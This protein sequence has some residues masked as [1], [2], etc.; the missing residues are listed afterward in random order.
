MLRPGEYKE[1][2]QRAYQVLGAAAWCQNHTD[3]EGWYNEGYIDACAR[4]SLDRLNGDLEREYRS[5]ESQSW[6]E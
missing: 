6:L 4:W 2:V 3:I 5:C 1:A